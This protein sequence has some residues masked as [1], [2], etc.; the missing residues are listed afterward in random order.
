M[1]TM[2]ICIH[3]ICN[4]KH[5]E[6]QDL[7]WICSLVVSYVLFQAYIVH[8]NIGPH[9]YTHKNITYYIHSQLVWWISHSAGHILSWLQIGQPQDKISLCN[10][11][12]IWNYPL[13][14]IT[15]FVGT[16]ILHILF[17]NKIDKIKVPRAWGAFFQ[18]NISSF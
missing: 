17:I 15:Y 13:L 2:V 3:L 7:N 8:F 11:R 6:I 16:S 4:I 18:S 14:Y 12:Y 1:Y 9:P 5:T 10:V